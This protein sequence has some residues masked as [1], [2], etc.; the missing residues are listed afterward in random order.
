[1]KKIIKQRKW[2]PRKINFN[3]ISR[4]H[5]RNYNQR[6]YNYRNSINRNNKYFDLLFDDE[7][8]NIRNLIHKLQKRLNIY[9]DVFLS[10]NF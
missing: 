7:I 8:D 3:F 1:M 5:H 6:Y 4:R 9:F 2:F 10:N